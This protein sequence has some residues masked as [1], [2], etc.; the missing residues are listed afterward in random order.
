MFKFSLTVL[1]AALSLALI[2]ASGNAAEQ[3]AGGLGRA[4]G[5]NEII[6]VYVQNHGGE[7]LGKITD[8]VVDAEGRIALVILSHGGFLGIHEK[9]T[10]IPFRSLRYDQAAKQVVLDI[11]KEELAAAPTF[12]MSDLSDQKGAENAYRYFGQQPYWSEGE[13]LFKGVNEPLEEVRTVQ[14]PLPYVSP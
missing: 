2:V 10:A 13:T 3:M 7:R 11:S 6:G 8:L 12:K 1:M 5:A 4:F 9:E 14:P